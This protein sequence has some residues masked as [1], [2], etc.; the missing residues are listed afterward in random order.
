MKRSLPVKL[1]LAA[2]LLFAQPVFSQPSPKD[3]FILTKE[4]DRIETKRLI[5]MLCKKGMGVKPDNQEAQRICE[6]CVEHM[7]GRFSGK[8][9]QKYRKRYGG[10]AIMMLIEEDSLLQQQFQDCYQLAENTNMLFAPGARKHYKEQ[11]MAAIRKDTAMKVDTLKLEAYCECAVNV[12]E[13]RGMTQ[14]LVNEF[15]DPNSLI[16]NEIAYKCGTPYVHLSSTAKWDAGSAADIT[17]AKMIDSVAMINVQAMTKIKVKIGNNIG[18]WLLD[19]GASDLLVSDSLT[20]RLL[21]Q[22]LLSRND[23]MGQQTYQLANGKTMLCDLYRVHHVQVGSFTVNNLVL[24]SS[25]ET[26]EFLL[27]KSFLNK[28]RRWSIDNKNEWLILE[29]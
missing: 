8:Q 22:N 21:Q 7:D 6:C 27:G 26:T 1:L 5:V 19:S 23:Y 14:Q 12:L 11:M 3:E 29:K 10:K 24:A 9:V 16:Y 17:G 28:F 2:L 25:R 18:V 20:K 13:K 4:G 15:A